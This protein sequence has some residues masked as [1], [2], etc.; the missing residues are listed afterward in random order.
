VRFV[1][2]GTGLREADPSAEAVPRQGLFAD[3]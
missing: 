3:D 1:W 2:D